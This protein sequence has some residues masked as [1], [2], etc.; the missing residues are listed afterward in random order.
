MPAVQIWLKIMLK[1][2]S[3]SENLSGNFMLEYNAT[4]EL[5]KRSAGG[6]RRHIGEVDR[7]ITHQLNTVK[8]AFTT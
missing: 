4:T 3:M 6:E 5:G 2:E 7:H 1:Y 8:K